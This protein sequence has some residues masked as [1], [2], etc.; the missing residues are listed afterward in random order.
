MLPLTP[1]DLPRASSHINDSYSLNKLPIRLLAGSPHHQQTRDFLN[2][3]VHVAHSVTTAP[4]QSQKKDLSPGPAVCT[5]KDCKLKSVKSALCFRCTKCCPKSSCRGQTSKFWGNLARPGSRTQNNPELEGRLC[6]PLPGPAQTRKISHSHKLLCQSPQ[7][8]LPV[9]GIASAYRQKCN[10]TGSK[11]N[12]PGVFQPTFSSSQTQQ[13]METNSGSEQIKPLPQSGEIQNGNTRNH[14]NIPPTRGVGHL[15]RLQRRLLP[16]TNTGT[17]QE[18]PQISYPG[19]DL[20]IQGTTLWSVHSPHGIHGSGQRGETDGLT[21]GYKDPP[22]PRR[23]VGESQIQTTLSPP[24]PDFSQNVSKTRLAG[25]H[26]KIRIGTKTNLQLRGLP[27]RPPVRSG[28]TYTGPVAKSAGP[29]T[30]TSINTDLFGQT[31][32]VPDRP[33]NSHREASSSGPATHETHLVASQKQLE[34]SGISR[35]LSLCP[36][37]YTHIYNGG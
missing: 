21:Q 34:G 35:R 3:K 20:P 11:S 7:E 29:D 4:R 22:V 28:Q 27:I 10:R 2:V 32:H 9:G 24:H 31:V 6:P 8:Q 17:I 18:I 1:Q 15:S 12:F 14:P 16:H 5:T 23:L 30:I 33:A 36:F 26:R 13:Q 19:P 37:L 25:E